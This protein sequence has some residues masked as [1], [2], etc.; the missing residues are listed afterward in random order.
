[1]VARLARRRLRARLWKGTRK[2]IHRCPPAQ[3]PTWHRSLDLDQCAHWQQKFARRRRSL[4]FVVARLSQ[5][6][7]VKEARV[8]LDEVN[9][10]RDDLDDMCKQAKIVCAT[11]S[12]LRVAIQWGPCR[13]AGPLPSGGVVEDLVTAPSAVQIATDMDGVLPRFAAHMRKHS[14][15]PRA[16]PP[17]RA[18]RTMLPLPHRTAMICRTR[19]RRR[20]TQRS[21]CRRVWAMLVAR[22]WISVTQLFDLRGTVC[23][24]CGS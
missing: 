7:M 1:M 24:R 6:G 22:P 11:F 19:A 23:M 9:G 8:V 21:A 14:H 12:Q 5:D 13:L 20:H 15:Y 18:A 3:V 16:S 4:L 10:W 17:N 2:C